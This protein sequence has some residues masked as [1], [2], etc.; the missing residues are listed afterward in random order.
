MNNSS[1]IRFFLG[2]F[3]S[4]IKE[5]ILFGK[6]YNQKLFQR[7]TKATAL[8]TV[9]LSKTFRDSNSYRERLRNTDFCYSIGFG[10]IISWCEYSRW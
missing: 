1:I 6:E 10:T 9:C 8:D 2:I 5:N 3:S 7:V 4:S